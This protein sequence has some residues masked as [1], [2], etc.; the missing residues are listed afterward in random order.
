LDVTGSGTVEPKDALEII[1]YL[2]L[3]PAV[4]AP[5]SPAVSPAVT[6]GLGST[7]RASD[8]ASVNSDALSPIPAQSPLV[9]AE[10]NLPIAAQ[11]SSP[12]ISPA[13]IATGQVNGFSNNVPVDNSASTA[14]ST[15]ALVIATSTNLSSAPVKPLRAFASASQMVYRQSSADPIDSLF[16]DPSLNWLDE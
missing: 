10:L 7:G 13:I 14:S 1:D 3:N 11:S 15:G 8:M 12:L 9:S 16:S 5:D 2:N 4:S 6:S